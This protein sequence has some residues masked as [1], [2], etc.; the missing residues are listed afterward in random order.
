MFLLNKT[1][2]LVYYY[3][4]IL[5]IDYTTQQVKLPKILLNIDIFML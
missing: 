4:K 3:T 1:S 5:S 2:N